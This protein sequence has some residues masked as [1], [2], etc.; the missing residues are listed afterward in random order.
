MVISSRMDIEKFNAHNFE[1]WKLKMGDI[2][3]NHGQWII[4]DLGMKTTVNS[5]NEWDKLEIR[6]RSEI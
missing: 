2:L 6:A 1:L 3:V 4:V 5:H